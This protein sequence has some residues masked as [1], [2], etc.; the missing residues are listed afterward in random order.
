M[1]C[2]SDPTYRVYVLSLFYLF[3][4]GILS[5]IYCGADTLEL[6]FFLSYL[7]SLFQG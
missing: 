5:Q 7:V 4:F 2:N 1:I 3:S 6:T